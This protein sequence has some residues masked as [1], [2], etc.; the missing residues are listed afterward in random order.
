MK[1]RYKAI[2]FSCMFGGLFSCMTSCKE[3]LDYENVNTIV[4]DAVW[5]D[6][7]M[8]NSFFN[9]IHG[10][11]NPGWIYN[12]ESSDEGASRPMVMSNY[13]RGQITVDNTNVSLDYNY[14]DKINFFLKNIEEVSSDVMPEHDKQ[15]LIG[16]AKF[17]RAWNYWNM[18]KWVG[19]VPLILEPQDISDKESLYRERNKTSECIA[20]ILKDLEDAIA[21]LPGKYEDQTND[22]GRITKAAAM[23]FKGKVLL[24]YASPLFNVNN[25]RDRWTSA[26]EA[27]KAALECLDKEGYGLYPDYKN[28][29]YDE[30]NIEVIMVNQYFYPGHAMGAFPSPASI[31]GNGNQPLLSTLLSFPK[32][33]GEYL[34]IDKERMKNDPDYNQAF[35]EDFYLNRDDRF[36]ASIYFGGVPYPSEQL[37]GDFTKNTT[38]W[39]AWEWNDAENRYDNLLSK[40]YAFIDNPGFTGFAQLKGMDPTLTFESSQ[41][42]QTDWIEMRYAEVLMNFGECANELGKS[43]EA[44]DVLYKIRKRANIEAGADGR[45]GIK[46]SSQDDIREAYIVERQAEFV[47]ENKRFEDLRRWKRYDIMNE[48]GTRQGLYLVLKPGSS[49]PTFDESI[50]DPEVRKRFRMDYIENLD[51]D[52]TYRFNLDLNHWFYALNPGQISQSKNKLEQN[53]EWGGTFDP[54]L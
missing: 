35:M 27:N 34:T 13:L 48:Q 51:G 53:V 50:L 11:L 38:L 43:D 31:S 5:K 12:A 30:R 45:Y 36:Y 37:K 39:Y 47:Y 32:K 20:Q 25:E 18:V 16:Q 42:G 52:P 21:V 49:L 14:I 29:W 17:W 54:L 24:H 6:A 41:N 46:A 1:N 19:G 2:L 4:P 7:A 9:D 33:N 26:Y 22:Y 44:L 10:G 15:L 40:Y 3:G 28:I 8:I 23:S